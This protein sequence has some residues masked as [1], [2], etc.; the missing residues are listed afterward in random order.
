MLPA[1]RAEKKLG[2]NPITTPNSSWLTI[3]FS[4]KLSSNSF[5][6]QRL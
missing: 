6:I 3:D 4:I 2:G 5:P 1:A